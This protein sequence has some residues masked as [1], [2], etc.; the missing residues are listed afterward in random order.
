MARTREV[1]KKS[2]DRFL[3]LILLALM[4]VASHCAEQ[5][6]AYSSAYDEGPM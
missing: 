6:S 3:V 2:W 1:A 4:G 5:R